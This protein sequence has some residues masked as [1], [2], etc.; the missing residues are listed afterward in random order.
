LADPAQADAE[1]AV[2]ETEREIVE[3]SEVI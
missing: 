3:R 1:A 2:L